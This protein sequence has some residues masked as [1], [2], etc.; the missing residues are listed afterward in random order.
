MK[1]RVGVS[2]WSQ[3]F[4]DSAHRV[5]SKDFDFLPKAQH[6]AGQVGHMIATDSGYGDFHLMSGRNQGLVY[7]VRRVVRGASNITNRFAV[8]A[9]LP[10][11]P[12]PGSTIWIA[13][14]ARDASS[15]LSASSNT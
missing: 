1:V 7:E 5:T 15:P 3:V 10:Q 8:R 11:S 2:M 12:V 13:P 9:A 4:I 14:S 6:L